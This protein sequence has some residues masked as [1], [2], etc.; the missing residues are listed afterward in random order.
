M[1]DI[2]IDLVPF[3]FYSSKRQIGFINIT[4]DATG[5]V[6]IGNYKYR[7]EDGNDNIILEGTYK[8]FK[9]NKGIFLLLKEILDDAYGGV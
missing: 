5:N 3:G 1:I 8:G 4:N 9:R 6:E 2:K 7:I